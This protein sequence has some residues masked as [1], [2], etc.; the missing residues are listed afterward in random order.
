[1]VSTITVRP[2]SD[3]YYHHY[4]P[5]LPTTHYDRVDE[6]SRDYVYI[7]MTGTAWWTDTFQ[8]VKP[9]PQGVIKNI[10]VNAICIAG[11]TGNT[12]YHKAVLYH[13]DHAVAEGSQQYTTVTDPPVYP[14]L[15]CDL[16]P[17]T[18]SPWSWDDLDELE[19]GIR[20]KCGNV[21]H[22]GRCELVYM[23]ISWDYPTA[24][25]GAQ[26]IGLTTL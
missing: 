4:D 26:I 6:A 22:V 17:W 10:T 19:F 7:S 25:G 16:N 13:P 23:V 3:G 8:F 11:G 18:S 9:T 15:S 21:S 20:G 2:S 24:C 12:S 14:T 1:M 5:A